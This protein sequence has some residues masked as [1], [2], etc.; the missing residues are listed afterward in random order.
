M[1]AVYVD[2]TLFF[3][4]KEENIDKL[5]SKLKKDSNMDLE[6]ENSVA[7]F[8]GAHIDKKE[9]DVIKLTQS[10]LAKQIVN[11][12]II[13]EKS[14]K[15]TPAISTPL[16][17]DEDGESG[18]AP[19]SYA[20]V[21]G[22]L[23]YLQGYSRPDLTYAVSQCVHFTH[24]YKRSHEEAL[25]RICQYLKCTMEEELFLKPNIEFDVNVYVDADFAGLWP[26]ED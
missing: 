15:F 8:L 13:G 2:D 26:Y 5:I 1:C 19:Y 9:N 12:L 4:P 20:S 6:V 22:M 14:R 11:T 23:Q 3:S 24:S 18:N 21:I 17:K 10:G 7:G 16:A 25:E